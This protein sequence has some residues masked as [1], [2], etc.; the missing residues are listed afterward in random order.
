MKTNGWRCIFTNHKLHMCLALISSFIISMTNFE[1][2]AGV[3]HYSH[4]W[5]YRTSRKTLIY[6][7][8]AS[9]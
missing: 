2:C 7:A 4:T 5:I 3:F 9:P 6:V 1:L 8:Q